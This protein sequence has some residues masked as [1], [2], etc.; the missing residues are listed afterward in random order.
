MVAR[1]QYV[2]LHLAL[3]LVWRLLHYRFD[4]PMIDREN[5]LSMYFHKALKNIGRLDW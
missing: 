2:E 5:L 1:H 4:L 3:H